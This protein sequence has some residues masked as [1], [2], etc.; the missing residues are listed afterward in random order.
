MNAC[1][2]SLIFIYGIF[3]FYDIQSKKHMFILLFVNK[4][5]IVKRLAVKDQNILNL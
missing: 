2:L 5:N 3:T 4:F 1:I